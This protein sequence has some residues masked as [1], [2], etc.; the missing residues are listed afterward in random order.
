MPNH[1]DYPTKI[2]LNSNDD[3]N[4]LIAHHG[5][6]LNWPYKDCVWRVSKLKK[7]PKVTKLFCILWRT[8]KKLANFWSRRNLAT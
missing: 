3:K 1:T 5:V 6:V 7:P 4:F 2:G 8:Q